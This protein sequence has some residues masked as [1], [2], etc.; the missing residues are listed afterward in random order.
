MLRNFAATFVVGVILRVV[1]YVPAGAMSFGGLDPEA[2]M[3]LFPGRWV[4]ASGAVWAAAALAAVWG[5]SAVVWGFS[6]GYWRLQRW[7]VRRS[8]RRWAQLR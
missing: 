8:F 7:S 1:A 2:S 3:G 6:M 4:A 5:A